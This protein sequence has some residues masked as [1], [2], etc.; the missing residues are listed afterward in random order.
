MRRVYV[1][2]TALAVV[3]LAAACGSSSG[4]SASSTTSPSAT[5]S[6]SSL[7]AML[8]ASIRSSGVLTD[9]VNSPYPPMEFQAQTGGPIVGVDI[10]LATAAAKLL[11]VKLQVTNT[12]NFSEL[13]PAVESNRTDIVWSATFDLKSRLG[14]VHFV[15]YFRTGDE[16]LGLEATSANLTTNKDLCG[17]T[18][19][20]QAGTSF[21]VQIA[22]LSAKLCGSSSSMKV[23]TVQTPPE[24]ALQ[25]KIGRAAALIN[26]PESNAYLASQQPGQWHVIGTIFSPVYF[27]VMFS[28]DDPELGLAIQA[29]LKELMK[30]GTYGRVLSDWHLGTSA[31]SS[32]SIDTQP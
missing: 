31:L 12:P 23:L 16:F 6:A 7:N 3:L 17:K 13:I 32:P 27:G 4:G 20:V 21:P 15:D 2:C 25:V 11:G 1:F 30:N 14:T 10:S 5:S 19:A 26:G 18:I 29:A 22:E 9:L 8:P 28:K 24:Q